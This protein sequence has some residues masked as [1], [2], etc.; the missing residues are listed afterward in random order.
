VLIL[1]NIKSSNQT[2]PIRLQDK[3]NIAYVVKEEV[4]HT[5]F[6]EGIITAIEGMIMTIAF[7]FPHGIKKMIPNPALRSKKELQT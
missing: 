3:V 2:A 4:V 1:L 7:K 6:G 5:E